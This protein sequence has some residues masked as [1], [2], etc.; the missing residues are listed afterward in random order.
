MPETRILPTEYVTDPNL[1]VTS[2]GKTIRSEEMII[3]MGPQHPSTHGVL[4]LELVLDGEIVMDV[5]PH[6]GYL[7]T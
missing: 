5:I 7:N 2:S 6:I 4:R 3:N 1:R